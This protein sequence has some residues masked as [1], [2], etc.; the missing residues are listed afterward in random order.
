MFFFELAFSQPVFYF[1]VVVSVIFSIVLH[2]LAHGWAAIW[3]GDDTPRAT[4][5]MTPDPITHMGGFGLAA[6]FLIGIGWGAMP[7]D[8]SRFRS[9][10]GDA[11]VSFAGPAMNL[12]LAIVSLT[13]FGLVFRGSEAGS[14]VEANVRLAVFI[15]GWYN[16]V[17]FLFNLIPVVP[18]DG[19]RILASF[20]RNY[21][22]WVHENPQVHQFLFIAMF[23]TIMGLERT[24]YGL[25][26]MTGNL[27]AQFIG[28]FGADVPF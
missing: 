25:F 2:E 21:A 19:S 27:A 18:L 16:L 6:V 28:L 1:T 8:P 4:G 7:V 3:Q 13:I 20:N 15:F 14:Q 5:H 22:R 24:E 23:I 9:R 10:Y 11:I 17:L 26:S 12:L